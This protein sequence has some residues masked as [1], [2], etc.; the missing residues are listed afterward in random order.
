MHKKTVVLLS[1][2][3]VMAA[4]G[5]SDVKSNL[6][7]DRPAPDEFRVMSRAPLTL[8]PDFNLRPPAPG[9]EQLAAKSPETIAKESLIG[10]RAENNSAISAE[11]SKLLE[12]TGAANADP[13][14]RATVDRETQQLIDA[15]TSI[16]GKIRNFDPQ[17]PVVDAAAER[18]RIEKNKAAGL[19]VNTGDTPMVKPRKKGL[20]ER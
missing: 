1:I 19:P 17:A 20:F 16:L 11:E 9:A 8:P 2:L 6:G 3:C 5:C 4:T 10:A 18:E 14:I 12:L 7:L 13:T 15:N